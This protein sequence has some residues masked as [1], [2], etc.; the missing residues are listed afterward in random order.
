MLKTRAEKRNAILRSQIEVAQRG[1]EHFI[2]ELAALIKDRDAPS[3]PVGNIRM[4]LERGECP[5]RVCLRLLSE[6][7]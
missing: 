7:E 1:A 4:S 6:A 2:S 3:L 5:C